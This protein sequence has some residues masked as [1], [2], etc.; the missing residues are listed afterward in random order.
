[1]DLS[2]EAFDK[3]LTVF[4]V[5]LSSVDL[6]KS[7][8]SSLTRNKSAA[9]ENRNVLD[10]KLKKPK[11]PRKNVAT[12]LGVRAKVGM[13]NSTLHLTAQLYDTLVP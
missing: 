13:Q 1:M 4:A 7:W 5:E 10:A 12:C 8:V 9:R 2:H 6:V 11:S 3:T